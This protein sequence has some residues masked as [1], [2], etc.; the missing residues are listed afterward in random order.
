MPG[1]MYSAAFEGVSVSV[2][3]DFFEITAP[4]TMMVELHEVHITQDDNETSQQ[5]PVRI[6]RV[7][8]TVTGGSGGSSATPRK[9]EVGSPSA[10][11]TV[12]VNNTTVAT[13]GT[14]E[15]LRR[16]GD[17]VLNGWHWVFLPETRIWIPPSGVV[18]VRLAT[19]PGAALTMS[20]ELIFNEIG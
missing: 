9:L 19:A 10:S 18:V 11:S 16:I 5:L 13:G 7:T 3:Q 17:N 20:G 6:L 4:S 8:P 15:V 2:A 1:R 12:D 14:L